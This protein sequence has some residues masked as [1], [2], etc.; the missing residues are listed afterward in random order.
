M[1]GGIGPPIHTRTEV[2]MM[3]HPYTYS[4]GRM[5]LRANLSP[6]TIIDLPPNIEDSQAMSK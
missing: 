1:Y 6:N 3:T 4:G 5:Y 2:L